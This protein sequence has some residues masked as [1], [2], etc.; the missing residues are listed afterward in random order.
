MDEN[1]LWHHYSKDREVVIRDQLFDLYIDWAEDIASLIFNQ[2]NISGLHY[3]E[4]CQ[5][6]YQ[7]LLEAIERFEP[8]RG[9]RFR[10]YGQYRV[11]GAI[12]SHL[13]KV[14]EDARYYAD[15]GRYLNALTEPTAQPETQ[16]S[17]EPV[18]ELVSLVMNMAVEFLL[19]EPECD[20]THMTGDFYSS[21]EINTIAQRIRDHVDSLEQ[22]MQSVV[23]LYYFE[24]MTFE[25]ITHI[26]ELS[27]ARI[28]QLHSRAI[29]TL[30]T[31]VGW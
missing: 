23:R 5:W 24:D 25:R 18:S 27:S 22:P 1:A 13:P 16:S 6:A 26:L 10:T 12:F 14:S 19:Q 21:P 2:T 7:G 15:R 3:E 20:L 11:R 17:D 4:V 30:R 31:R 28:S 8:E 9:V 29:V